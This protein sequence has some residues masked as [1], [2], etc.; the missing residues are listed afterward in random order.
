MPLVAGFPLFSSNMVVI[1]NGRAS[2]KAAPRGMPPCF[3]FVRV[4]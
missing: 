1:E 4:D 2:G 3:A